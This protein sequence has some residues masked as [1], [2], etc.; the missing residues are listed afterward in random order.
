MHVYIRSMCNWQICVQYHN[1]FY[2]TW[3][4]MLFPVIMER[5]CSYIMIIS[6]VM[7]E[8][9]PKHFGE[10]SVSNKKVFF[11]CLTGIYFLA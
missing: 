9:Q 2:T 8:E 11:Y 3:K 7:S 10:S 6:L 4:V 1:I 5:V